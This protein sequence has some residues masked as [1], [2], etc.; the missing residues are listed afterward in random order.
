[1]TLATEQ[2]F[3]EWLSLATASRGWTL[4]EQ[5]DLHEGIAQ[6]RQGLAT[7]RTTGA[8]MFVS[9]FLTLLARAYLQA[10]QAEEAQSAL[11]EALATVEKTE[12][13]LWDAEIYRLQGAVLVNSGTTGAA[14]R[15]EGCLLQALAKARQRQARSL[16]L[17][18]ALDLARLWQRQGKRGEATQL[19]EDVYGWFTEGF[20]TAD[21]QAA[22][23]LLQQLRAG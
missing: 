7:Y 12:G 8:L 18:A 14:T 9:Y 6:M 20:A 19:L 2:K 13:R 23:A 4:T 5:G 17:R 10:G 11:E 21:L 1:M 16:E 15:A 22:A 3:T